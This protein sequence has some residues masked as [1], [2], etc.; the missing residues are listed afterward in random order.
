[1]LEQGKT[2]NVTPIKCEAKEGTD[3]LKEI[4]YRI[5]D[6]LYANSGK[7]LFQRQAEKLYQDL[8]ALGKELSLLQVPDRA[9]AKKAELLTKLRVVCNSLNVYRKQQQTSEDL[10][11]MQRCLNWYTHRYIEARDNLTPEK[12]LELLMESK[13]LRDCVYPWDESLKTV[14]LIKANRQL[15]NYLTT[16]FQI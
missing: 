2:L 12:A 11:A 3:K 8:C 7:Y 1:M 14:N 6:L 9:S 15:I 10:D 5:N 4:H 13:E 16:E